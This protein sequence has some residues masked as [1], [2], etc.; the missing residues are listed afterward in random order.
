MIMVM[1]GFTGGVQRQQQVF[2]LSAWNS[3]ATS[4]NPE[5]LDP[6]TAVTLFEYCTSYSSD[7]LVREPIIS[8]S[9]TMVDI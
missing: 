3:V 1:R 9:G 8:V 6:S 2:R 7:L 4:P 5:I